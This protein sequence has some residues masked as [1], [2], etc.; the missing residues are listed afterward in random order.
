MAPAAARRA[1]MVAGT[2]CTDEVLM[3][4]KRAMASVA[5]SCSGLRVWRSCIA[6]R[7]SGGVALARPSM[8]GAKFMM[9]ERCAG[10]SAGTSGKS[11]RKNGRVIADGDPAA[12]MKDAAVID[13]YLGAHA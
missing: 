10:W 11:R 3:A 1:M 7:P 2:S 6:L 9:S 4:R 5:T 13:A 8:L 12:V